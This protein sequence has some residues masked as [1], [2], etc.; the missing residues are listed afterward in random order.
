MLQGI[1]ELIKSAWK[2]II[3]GLGKVWNFIKEKITGHAIGTNAAQRGLA[4]VGEKGPELVNFG[5]GEKVYNNTNTT[6]ILQ[7]AGGGSVFNVTFENTVDTTAYAM[8]KQL[9]G[10]QRSLA[11]NGII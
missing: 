6:K 2:G 1:W 4:L 8:M 3:G 10:Y 9:K 5:G 7:N 11:F